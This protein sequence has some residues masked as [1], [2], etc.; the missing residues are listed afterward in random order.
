MQSLLNLVPNISPEQRA[1]VSLDLAVVEQISLAQNA[2]PGAPVAH[3]VDR[4]RAAEY[5]ANYLRL[6]NEELAHQPQEE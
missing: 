6:L 5:L 3:I 4:R 2:Y 1:A